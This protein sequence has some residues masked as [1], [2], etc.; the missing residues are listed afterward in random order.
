VQKEVQRPSKSTAASSINGSL[1][2]DGRQR[3][4]KNAMLK[5]SN[6]P[7]SPY[8]QPDTP[9][10]VFKLNLLKHLEM[11]RMPLPEQKEHDMECGRSCHIIERNHTIEIINEFVKGVDNSAGID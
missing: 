9:A 2:N 8:F 3:G 1:I 7:P 5:P 4:L 10:S 6:T 11:L